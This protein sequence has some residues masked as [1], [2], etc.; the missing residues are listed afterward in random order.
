MTVQTRSMTKIQSSDYMSNID[1]NKEDLKKIINKLNNTSNIVE[2]VCMYPIFLTGI[3]I[4][5]SGIYYL[6][7]ILS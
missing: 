6:N 5:F 7:L 3:S 4:V 1:C 2:N